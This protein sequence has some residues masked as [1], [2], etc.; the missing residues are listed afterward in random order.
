M[1]NV[2]RNLCIYLFILIKV[3]KNIVP[4][5]WFILLQR[6]RHYLYWLPFSMIKIPSKIIKIAV[7]VLIIFSFSHK[8]LYFLLWTFPSSSEMCCQPLEVGQKTDVS[9]ILC[10]V[11]CCIRSMAKTCAIAFCFLFYSL[12]YTQI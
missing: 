6:E 12:A 10:F 1:L 5:S 7:V 8:I 4:L 2:K 9:F 3:N 11:S